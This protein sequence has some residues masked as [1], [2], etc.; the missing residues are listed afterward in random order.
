M[1][2][3]YLDLAASNRVLLLRWIQEFLQRGSATV[4]TF[5]LEV[6]DER[7]K[8]QMH[9]TNNTAWIGSGTGADLYVYTPL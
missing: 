5:D 9:A 7:I 1:L 3:D 8:M 4:V 2:T 6:V